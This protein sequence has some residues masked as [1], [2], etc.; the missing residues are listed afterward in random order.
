MRGVRFNHN[1]SEQTVD[2]T[3]GPAGDWISLQHAS[4]GTDALVRLGEQ[5]LGK[6]S[7]LMT[8]A[9]ENMLRSSCRG[10]VDDERPGKII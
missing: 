6:C 8:S 2:K 9:R 4:V 7:G 3:H 5:K 10:Q 1:I